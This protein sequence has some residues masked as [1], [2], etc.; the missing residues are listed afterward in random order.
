MQWHVKVVEV[1]R[2]LVR[3]PKGSRPLG[4]Y[5]CRWENNIKMDL[6]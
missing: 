3:T 6:T 4:K 5:R 2:D 1:F